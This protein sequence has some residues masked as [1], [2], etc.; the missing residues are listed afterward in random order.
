MLSIILMLG[1]SACSKESKFGVQQFTERMNVQFESE[2]DTASFLLA[3]HEIGEEYLVCEKDEML[4][5][6]NLNTDQKIK[7]VGLVLTEDCDI[8]QGINTFAQSCAVF[9]G[10]DLDEQRSTLLNCGITAEGIKYADSSF[11]ITVGKYQYSVVCSEF[12]ICL[13]CDRV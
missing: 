11:H 7:G 4:I 2:L 1:L 5:A 6:L 12:G 13:F 10:T 3:T 9:I 8:S